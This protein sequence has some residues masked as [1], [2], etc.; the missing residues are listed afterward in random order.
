VTFAVTGGEDADLFR[1]NEDDEL[2]F[3]AAP[4]FEGASEDGD[5]VY[6]VEVT[7]T[8]AEGAPARQAI[9]VTV[10]NDPEDDP[11]PDQVASPDFLF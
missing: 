1:V 10:T 5:D 4:D 3:M 8:D 7:A 2:A 11:T 6:E 9:A